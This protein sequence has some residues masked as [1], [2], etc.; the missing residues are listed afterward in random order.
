M[1]INWNFDKGCYELE[2]SEHELGTNIFALTTAAIE[3]KD[4]HVKSLQEEFL[5]SLYDEW[6]N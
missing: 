5:K 4:S 3:T 6:I 1:K 2:M